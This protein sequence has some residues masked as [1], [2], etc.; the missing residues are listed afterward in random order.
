MH[1][2]DVGTTLGCNKNDQEVDTVVAS[3]DAEAGRTQEA[4][5]LSRKRQAVSMGKK[6]DEG[7]TGALR[8]D[9]TL[10]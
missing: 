1:L 6:S 2:R 8:G 5:V 7:I 4:G 9:I 3:V 10:S